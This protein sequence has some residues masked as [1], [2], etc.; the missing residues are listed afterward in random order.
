M[1]DF[2]KKISSLIA[3]DGSGFALLCRICR[4]VMALLTKNRF[5]KFG[6]SS[7]ANYTSVHTL[8]QYKGDTNAG[9]STLH[10]NGGGILFRSDR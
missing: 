6:L 10:R 8:A 7:F 3:V 9:N 1:L 4:S 2:L 5:S